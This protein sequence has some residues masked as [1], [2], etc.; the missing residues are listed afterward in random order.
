M[1]EPEKSAQKLYLAGIH[2]RL[3]KLEAA[4]AGHHRDPA[5]TFR[6]TKNTTAP[7]GPS[8]MKSPAQVAVRR[9]RHSEEPGAGIPHAGICEGD[10]RQLA[11]LPH[12]PKFER[13]PPRL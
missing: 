10:A 2:G 13:H 4:P 6:S 1:A 11:F 8:A 12:S 9:A 7:I 3:G 5:A